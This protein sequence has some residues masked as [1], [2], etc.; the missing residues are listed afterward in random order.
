[1][2]ER[3]SHPGHDSALH[4]EARDWLLLLTSGRAT[5]DDA[6]AF[7]R[8]CSLSEMH[9]QAF[10]ETRLLWDN[11]GV[12]ARSL[13]QREQAVVVPASRRM[14]RRA[15]LGGAVA[16]SAA[17]LAARSPLNLW[18]S[19][20]DAMADY[21][22]ATGEQRQVELTSGVVVEMNTQT[23]MNVRTSGGRVVGVE[24][25]TGEIQLQ[26]SRELAGS[27]EIRALHGGIHAASGALCN[28]RCLDGQVQVTGLDGNVRV[29]CQGRSELL[30]RAQQTGYG[31]QG[32][33]AVAVADT[34][35]AVAWRRRVLVFDDRP[36][37]EVITEINRY[38]P[39][40]IILTND[41][42]AARKVHAQVSLNQLGDVA[43]L[44]HQAFGASVRSL[45][46]GIVL[47]S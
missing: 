36:L 34:D 6:S 8:W 16:A 9:A 43:S 23:A 15:F 2:S 47:V 26:V 22:T 5:T 45:P 17:L 33:S 12:A 31:S 35:E 37:S 19:L 32:L 25:L 29:E 42:L 10:A 14:S 3:F 18:P 11:L 41:V 13:H 46:G 38:R 30:G 24:L 39:G 27:F 28:V 40:K 44:I 4:G 7:R 1:M 20:P 21:R